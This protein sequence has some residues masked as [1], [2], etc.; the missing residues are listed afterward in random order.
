MNLIQLLFS[1][2]GRISRKQYWTGL[3]INL[4]VVLIAIITLH[5]DIPLTAILPFLF[6]LWSGWALRVKRKHDL[7]HSALYIAWSLEVDFAK[8]TTGPN[9]MAP[10][11]WLSI[12]H[13]ERSAAIQFAPS[14]INGWLRSARNDEN[15]I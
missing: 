15:L 8:G 13:S 11:R 5:S 3:I 12:R 6:C 14:H 10:T 4:P 1:F 7:G 2:K 9:N